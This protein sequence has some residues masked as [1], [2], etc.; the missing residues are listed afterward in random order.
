[1][2]KLPRWF[3]QRQRASGGDETSDVTQQATGDATEAP[4]PRRGLQ[5]FRSLRH[6]DFRILWIGLAIVSAGQWLEQAAIGWQVLA[7]SDSPF[8]VGVSYGS[9]ALPFLL[10]GPIAGILADRFERRSLI[11]ASQLYLA[12]VITLLAVLNLTGVIVLWQILVLTLALG[13]GWTLNNAARY[14]FI[15]QL[16]PSEHLMNAVALGSIGFNISRTIG[17]FVAGVLL[18]VLDFGVVFA[19]AAGIYAIVLVTTFMIRTRSRPGGSSEESYWTSAKEGIRYVRGNRPLYALVMFGFLPVTIGMPYLA[20]MP[21]FARD[22]LGQTEVGF[23]ILLGASGTGALIG[24]L[25]LASMGNPRR[26]VAAMLIFGL[27]FGAGLIG[28]GLSHSF[29][30][31]L[32]MVALTGG[33]F[34]MYITVNNTMIQM[35]VDDDMRGRVMS[36]VM[37]QFGLTPLGAMVAAGVAEILSPG[38]AVVGMGAIVMIIG[39]VAFVAMPK[40]RDMDPS[41]LA[42][43][44]RFP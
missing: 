14:S 8:W 4:P 35:L 43:P 20:L 30:L 25:I 6:R 32:A 40:F 34:M 11:A 18:A 19:I 31:S 26:P 9:R 15:P 36:V 3:P 29:P 16:V 23:G 44:K 38:A 33:M 41:S 37:M 13:A 1:L 10:V 5:T 17:P 24:S 7:I 21:V 28:F 39:A 42:R 2:K 12:L 27:G 22:V